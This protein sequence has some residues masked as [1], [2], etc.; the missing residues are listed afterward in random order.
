MIIYIIINT[1]STKFESLQNLA[2]TQLETMTV[3]SVL[4]HKGW[5]PSEKPWVWSRIG[6]TSGWDV[7]GL[8]T[9]TNITSGHSLLVCKQDVSASLNHVLFSICPH[10]CFNMPQHCQMIFND[11]LSTSIGL[12]VG[13]Q[14]SSSGTHLWR[15]LWCSTGAERRTWDVA[16]V[17]KGQVTSGNHV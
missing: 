15:A 13:L 17:C 12:P 3:C 14:G 11:V 2:F 4:A 10:E 5:R 7:G 9:L 6:A 8:L 1:P 16:G